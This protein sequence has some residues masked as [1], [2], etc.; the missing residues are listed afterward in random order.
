MMWPGAGFSVL[1]DLG[2]C[3]LPATGFIGKPVPQLQLAG[4][5]SYRMIQQVIK[6]NLYLQ[7]KQILSYKK[8]CCELRFPRLL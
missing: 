8:M 1:V 4:V 2:A 5:K 3:V 6:A 7:Y